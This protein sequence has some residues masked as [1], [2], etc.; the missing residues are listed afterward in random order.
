MTVDAFNAAF[1]LSHPTF[2]RKLLRKPRQPKVVVMALKPKYA[3]AIYEG[4]KT[5]EFRKVPP[6][7]F[8]RIYIYESAPVS[9]VTGWVYFSESV[10]GIPLVVWDMVKT[11]RICEKNLPGLSYSELE[12]YAGKKLVTALHVHEAIRSDRPIAFE[13]KPPQNWGRFRIVARAPAA[14]PTE[15]EAAI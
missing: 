4:R 2:A 9:A 1:L 5:W 11:A 15:S 7:L 13:A 10:T 6:P 14:N 3:K 12:Q 8:T